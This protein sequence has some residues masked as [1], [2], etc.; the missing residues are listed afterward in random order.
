MCRTCGKFVPMDKQTCDGNGCKDKK[1]ASNTKIWTEFNKALSSNDTAINIYASP[2]RHCHS[3]FPMQGLNL[4]RVGDMKTDTH[5]HTAYMCNCLIMQQEHIL[6]ISCDICK[7]MPT[8]IVFYLFYCDICEM[9]F[10]SM[11][12]YIFFMWYLWFFAS[13]QQILSI[14]P[15]I[16]VI[17]WVFSWTIALYRLYTPDSSGKHPSITNITGKYIKSVGLK[18]KIT[19]ITGKINKTTSIWTEFNKYHRKNIQHTI[20]VS[21]ILQTSQEKYIKLLAPPPK[22]TRFTRGRGRILSMLLQKV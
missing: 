11:L 16:F 2:P 6:F 19:N 7:I 21:R 20:D 3:V 22:A 5:T 10:K 18:Q 4:N 15:V 9:L 17:F 8:S 12:F 13:N 1:P 14:F